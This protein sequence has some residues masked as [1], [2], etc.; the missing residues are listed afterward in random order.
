MSYRQLTTPPHH[1]TKLHA[2]DPRLKRI[3]PHA[4]AY[5]AFSLRGCTYLPWNKLVHICIRKARHAPGPAARR[6]VSA[7]NPF[8]C[9]RTYVRRL[10][11]P[12]T[13][14]LLILPRFVLRA[15]VFIHSSPQKRSNSVSCTILCVFLFCAFSYSVRCPV[16]AT[17]PHPGARVGSAR[18]ISFSFASRER[19]GI[20]S[21]LLLSYSSPSRNAI[22]RYS[23][24]P[25]A[26]R[27]ERLYDTSPCAPHAAR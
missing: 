20:I 3:T 24:S 1:H 22:Q 8:L 12:R 5:P 13:P 18:A 17:R 19:C 7:L 6:G 4:R 10:L 26:H 27:G 21:R 16:P 15:S 9:V 25:C 2:L 23:P 11:P 14:A